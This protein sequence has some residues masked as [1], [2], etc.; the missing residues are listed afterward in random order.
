M[1]KIDPNELLNKQ[2]NISGRQW[3][4]PSVG[5]K[6]NI[7]LFHGQAQGQLTLTKKWKTE[8]RDVPRWFQ[9][10]YLTRNASKIK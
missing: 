2:G 3:P 6:P 8:K 9:V 10:T 1:N 5:S 4:E 7:V